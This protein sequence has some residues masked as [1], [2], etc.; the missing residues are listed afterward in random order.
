MATLIKS[1]VRGWLIGDE[2]ALDKQVVQ[3]SAL[4]AA[5]KKKRRMVLCK[6]L[7]DD[8]KPILPYDAEGNKAML[9]WKV[10]RFYLLKVRIVVPE[11]RDIQTMRRPVTDLLVAAIDCHQPYWRA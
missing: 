2:P 3:K 5:K 10:V 1:P 7:V 11:Q 4:R 6:N 8:R 9:G